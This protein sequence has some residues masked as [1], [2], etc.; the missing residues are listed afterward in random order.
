MPRN[1]NVIPKTPPGKDDP[2]K[3]KPT[4]PPKGKANDQA[5]Q[6]PPEIDP[7]G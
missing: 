3:P 4:K 2:K 6:P 5:E 7:G 1:N